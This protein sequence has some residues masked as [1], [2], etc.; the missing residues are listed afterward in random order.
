MTGALAITTMSMASSFA[1]DTDSTETSTP[2]VAE[3]DE[4]T[5]I[6]VQLA[7]GSVGDDRAS[8]YKDIKQRIARSVSQASPGGTIGDV[9]D[10]HHALDGFAITAPASARGAIKS[11][12]GV[13]DAFIDGQRE[14]VFYP[15]MSGDGGAAVADPAKE[16]RSDQVAG[17]GRGRVIEVIDASFD[18][19]H[20]AF[21]G[22]MD[23]AALR[24]P[25]AEMASLTS[26]L[27][28]GQGGAWISDK[29]PFVYDY[30]DRDTNPYIGDGYGP[31]DYTVHA[32][33]TR[34]AALAAANGVTYR[35]GA[36]D[37]QLIL[38]KV[39]SNSTRTVRDSD[40]LAAL[41]DAMVIKPDTVCVAFMANRD[42]GG[43][44]EALYDDVF[45]RL[46]SAGITVDAPAGDSGRAEWRTGVR[47]LGD[48]GAPAAYSS[49]LAAP[50]GNVNAAIPGKDYRRMP[51]TGEASAQVAGVGALVCQRMATDPM[52]A[53]MSEEDKSALVSN[54]LMGT[55]H[56]IVD[57][58]AADGTFWSPRWVG[59][60]MVDALEATTSSV[61]PSVVGAANP[62]RPKAELGESA[63]GWTF[64]IQLTNL[65]DTAHTYT[66]G[67]QALSEN[68]NGLLYTKHSTNWAG[69]GIDL[70]FSA[71]T[72]TVRA[73]S[74][75]TVTVSVNPTPQ[76]ASYASEKTPNGTFIDGAVTLTSADGQP[77]LTIP[78][79]GFY[80][81]ADET[82]I[83]DTPVY[84]EGMIGTSTMTF[85]GLTLG[86]L[87]PFDVE[88]A[89]AISAN[90]RHLY[91]I[92]RST[93]ENA[94]TYATP[95]TVLLRDVMSLTYIYRN[96][97]GD[98]VRSYTC[99]GAPKSRTVWNG[100]YSEVSTAEAACGSKPLFDG[101]DEQ[102]HAL[103][104][105]RYTLTIEGTTGGASPLTQRLTHEVTVDTA[106][107]VISNVQILGE[108]D[109]RKL[110]FDATDSSP[111]AAYGF[112]WSA[113]GEPF[114]REKVYGSDEREDDGRH[115]GHLEV[116]LSQIA[117]RSGA[118]PSTVYL[119][120]WDWPVNK[121]TVKVDLKPV[122][123][124]SLALSQ[125]DVTLSVGDSVTLNATHEPADA[126]ATDVAWSSSNE[127]VA[128]VSQD[129]TVTA[130]GAGDATVTVYDPTQPSLVS[131]SATIHVSAPSPARKAG[132][133]KRNGRG[134]WYR[135]EDG[136]YPSGESAVIDGNVYR[137][138]AS[139]YMRTGWVQWY[140]HAAYDA[141]ASG[142]LLSGVHWYYLSPQTGVMATG[143][144]KVG[145][146]WYYLLPANGAMATGWLKDGGH[147]YYLNRPSGAMATGWLRIWG[148]WYHFADNGQ[149]I[150]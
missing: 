45:A 128:T 3:A 70:T 106:P 15:E 131:A 84:G 64:Q 148:T 30:A 17:R 39:L 104:D 129:G 137:F 67:G 6:I 95:A 138:D 149:L 107:P 57:P 133:W 73:A 66:L 96:E 120:V 127:A 99:G 85:R 121:G 20:E 8:A 69:K 75:A 34:M 52:F 60:G 147:W 1:A 81:S 143:W 31:Q 28:A 144:V 51:G 141:Q 46:S 27:D 33:G 93:E 79:L 7:A 146:T 23:T 89:A 62:S 29:I 54:F 68:V 134:W 50:G 103:A 108:G 136:S 18:T 118:D 14:P 61:C 72:L 48:V 78:Y 112:S 32:H 37:A 43:D 36:P 76:F 150:A 126:S 40:M 122:P 16:T 19:S 101:Y 116:P 21:A 41:D 105:G 13:K 92:S 114:M 4:A 132:A 111:I 91:I 124:T 145:A 74:S 77:D 22:T 58:S 9:R 135:Y 98:V 53:G 24:L 117:E 113:D 47:D 71:D 83:F 90:D 5:T 2:G 44:A 139:G 25:Q 87:N 59:A 26:Q 35:G 65:S 125:T 94:R 11:V 12:Q 115:Y 56:P 55:A 10:Y 110:S 80:G 142:W 140:Y 123:M 102:G 49:V 109:E 100:R 97:A 130:V 88:D 82:P 63:S 38:A 86:Q 119:Q 42:L